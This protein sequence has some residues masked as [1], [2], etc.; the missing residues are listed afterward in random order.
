M[1]GDVRDYQRLES[2]LFGVNYV[3]H[4]AALKQ[5]PMAEMNPMEAV[6]TNIVGTHNVLC[7]SAHQQVEKVVC[8][9]T[10]KS[11]APS[12]CMG[13]TKGIGE[14]LIR[15]STRLYSNLDAVCVRLGNV[16][17]S[18][19]SVIPL[20][21]NQIEKNQSITLTDERMTRFIMTYEDVFQLLVHAFTTGEKGEVIISNMKACRILDL[22]KTV[23]LHYGLNV[24]KNILITGS[25]PGEKL[26]EE[27]FSPEEMQFI[28]QNDTYYHIGNQKV[29]WVT[30]TTP[31]RSDK[32]TLLDCNELE[33]L[34]RK[35]N[36]LKV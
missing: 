14:R 35:N 36:I 7:G 34:L 33:E 31:Y 5:V 15:S 8:L 20:W 4:A 11:V 32:C 21:K 16:L 10:D 13:M 18:R 23:C 19:G 28:Y 3:I 2:A 12:N 30:D 26:Y 22:A 29:C 17:D 24:E 25:R 27:L 6:A 1:I 9:S